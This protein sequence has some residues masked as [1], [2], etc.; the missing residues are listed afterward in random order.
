MGLD[1]P[2]AGAFQA[3]LRTLALLPAAA[4][5]PCA[6]GAAPEVMG[7]SHAL[8]IGDAAVPP[9]SSSSYVSASWTHPRHRRG[10]EVPGYGWK[11]VSPGRHAPRR[12]RGPRTPRCGR[13]PRVL[14]RR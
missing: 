12:P 10:I 14:G 7:C 1:F 13:K 2:R 6:A 9:S 11:G 8:F 5:C 3:G 4:R